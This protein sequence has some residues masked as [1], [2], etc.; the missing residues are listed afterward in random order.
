[1][2]IRDLIGE[3]Q[4]I[5]V[6]M[7]R[8]W[9][10]ETEA[11]YGTCDAI[12]GVRLHGAVFGLKQGVP[13]IGLAYE[14]KVAGMFEKVGLSQNA[15]PLE[16]PAEVIYQALRTEMGKFDRDS[17]SRTLSRCREEIE[18]YGDLAAELMSRGPAFAARSPGSNQP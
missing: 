3:T 13:T 9:P 10:E 18:Q 1:M 15:L 2:A 17:L 16:S 7:G 6:L 5:H 11:L 4:G 12:L 14:A 8:Y